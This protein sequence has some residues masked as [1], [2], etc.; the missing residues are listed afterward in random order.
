MN[1]VMLLRPLGLAAYSAG[2]P[3]SFVTIYEPFISSLSLSV[4]LLSFGCS[5]IIPHKFICS[6]TVGFR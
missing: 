3:S 2:F 6:R 5:D 1:A 4:V